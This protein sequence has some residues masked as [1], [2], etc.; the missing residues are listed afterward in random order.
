MSVYFLPTK[1][2]YRTGTVTITYPVG[3][4]QTLYM[5]GWGCTNCKVLPPG[6]N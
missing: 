4:T 6:A 3:Q 2:G 1:V 5:R